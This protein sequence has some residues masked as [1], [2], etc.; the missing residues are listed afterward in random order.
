MRVTNR[1]RNRE[2]FTAGLASLAGFLVVLAMVP[3]TAGAAFDTPLAAAVRQDDAAAVRALLDGGFDV[4]AREAGGR[5]GAPLGPC[6]WTGWTL[7]S[8]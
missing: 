5:G 8:C 7:P 2:T 3:G 1:A 6:A 4:N